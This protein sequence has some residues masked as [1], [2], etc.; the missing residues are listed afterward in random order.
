MTTCSPAVRPDL[1]SVMPF[2]VVP[3][4]TVRS[5]VLVVEPS[6]LTR[7]VVVPSVAV[8]HGQGGHLHD[9]TGRAGDDLGG[10]GGADEELVGRCGEGDRDREGRDPGTGVGHRADVG[11]GA[12]GGGPGRAGGAGAGR[13]GAVGPVARARACP[14]PGAGAGE[15]PAGSLGTRPSRMTRWTS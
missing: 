14:C 11:D 3:V 10:D 8:G 7:T 13:S 2:E 12:G 4:V 15:R 1:I 6:V 5:L 9:V